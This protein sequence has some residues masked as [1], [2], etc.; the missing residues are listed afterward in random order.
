MEAKVSVIIPA[1]NAERFL[2]RSVDSVVTQSFTDWELVVVDDG[3]TDTTPQLADEL[4]A[5]DPRITVVHKNANAGLAEAR[6]TGHAHAN[7]FYHFHLDADDTLPSDALDFLTRKADEHA[8]D[9]IIAGAS[10]VYKHKS[11]LINQREWEGIVDDK[12][13]MLA[14]IFDYRFQF[15]RGPC[16]SRGELWKK[17]DFFPIKDKI[18]P[19]EDFLMSTAIINKCN[20]IGVY[21]HS[22]YNYY[23]T[24][25]SLSETKP[26]SSQDGIKTLMCAIEEIL[27][28]TPHYEAIKPLFQDFVLSL[29]TFDI[30][31]VTPDPWIDKITHY[32]VSHSSMKI[33]VCRFLMRHEWLRIPVVTLHNYI[34]NLQ[35]A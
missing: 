33:K 8:L 32:D 5:T 16:F 35:G 12:E 21:N 6:R 30:H 25:G 22:V 7:G 20:C 28:S 23:K 24:E 15:L 14:L 11:H 3:S 27:A 29:V 13:K 34:R 2:R 1:Y 9:F 4:A 17:H 10:R 19:S 31:K 26:F 18:I